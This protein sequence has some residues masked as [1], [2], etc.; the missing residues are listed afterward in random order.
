MSKY[1]KVL[2]KKDKVESIIPTKGYELLKKKYQFI[3]YVNEDGSP[4]TGVTDS[5]TTKAEPVKKNDAE[6]VGGDESNGAS[7]EA[8]TSTQT[9]VAEK[10]AKVEDPELIELRAQ[11]EA[12]SGKKA[13]GRWNKESLITKIQE[14]SNEG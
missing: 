10:P 5:K 6:V 3:A 14:V 13:N 8:G 12:K 11:Y 2:H 7:P 9:P 4:Y 1:V